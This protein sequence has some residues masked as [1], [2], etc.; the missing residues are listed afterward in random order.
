M[1]RNAPKDAGIMEGNVQRNGN[2][3]TK[4][5]IGNKTIIRKRSPR[6]LII[7]GCR[8]EKGISRESRRSK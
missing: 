2:H 7:W 4:H 6:N 1:Q 5:K 8:E 3:P